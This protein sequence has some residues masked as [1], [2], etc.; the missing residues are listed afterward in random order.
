MWYLISGCELD[1]Y[2][3]EGKAIYLI[4]VR[5]CESYE[6][7]H[8]RGAINIPC[9]QIMGQITQ[10]PFDRLIV[11]YCY[12]GPRSMLVARELSGFGYQ[13]ADVYGG[14]EGYRGKYLT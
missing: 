9:E 11:L 3:D 8:I 2:M 4:D 14:I 5:D 12:R 6:K 10:I 1:Q 13:V 7:R